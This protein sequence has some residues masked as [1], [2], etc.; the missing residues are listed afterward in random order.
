VQF[1]WGQIVPSIFLR[2]ISNILGDLIFRG[3]KTLSIAHFR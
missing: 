2:L 3:R 1:S